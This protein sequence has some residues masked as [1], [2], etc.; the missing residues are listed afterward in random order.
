MLFFFQVECCATTDTDS[1]E[2]DR[3]IEKML[4]K[5]GRD[6]YKLRKSKTASKG[7]LDVHAFKEKMAFFTN[8]KTDVPVIAGD[9]GT[10]VAASGVNAAA[11]DSED[12]ASEEQEEQRPSRSEQLMETAAVNRLTSLSSET[13]NTLTE[14]DSVVSGLMPSSSNGSQ[15]VTSSLQQQ[16]Q[17][18]QQLQQPEE[19]KERYSYEIDP[20]IGVIV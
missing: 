3:R 9:G 13:V 2:E 5:T 16:Q 12:T 18:Q 4:K 15:Q 14:D 10:A 6:I 17:Q 11:E 20:D 8:L 7:Q 19:E 1:K